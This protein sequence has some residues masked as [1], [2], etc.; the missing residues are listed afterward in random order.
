MHWQGVFPDKQNQI[1]INFFIEFTGMCVTTE[2]FHQV[3]TNALFTSPHH[4]LELV[5]L[6]NLFLPLASYFECYHQKAKS[7]K[8]SKCLFKS[9]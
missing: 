6:G 3:K 7:S 8:D 9:C 2:Y 4:V 1:T 5:I